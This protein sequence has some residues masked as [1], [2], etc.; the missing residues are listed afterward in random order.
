MTDINA[1]D[2]PFRLVT[3]ASLTDG[4]ITTR[5]DLLEYLDESGGIPLGNDPP[6]PADA[7]HWWERFISDLYSLLHRLEVLWAPAPPY[8]RLSYREGEDEYNRIRARL[9]VE[10][11]DNLPPVNMASTEAAGARLQEQ[12]GGTAPPKPSA[13]PTDKISLALAI[14]RKHPEWSDRKVA[15]T[16]GCTPSNLSQSKAWKAARKAIRGIG[17]EGIR[18][19]G[20]HRARDNSNKNR[21]R[22]MDQ[23]ADDDETG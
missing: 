14:L 21:G 4:T 17:E 6:F 18:R 1:A 22:D 15:E 23:Y 9:R 3:T 2:L 10:E 20:K 16:V 5:R 11:G 19:G 7:P 12:G 13:E 8:I